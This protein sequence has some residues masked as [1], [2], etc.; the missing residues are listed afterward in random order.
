MPFSLR[1]P[2]DPMPPAT[3]PPP[4]AGLTLVEVLMA[5]AILGISAAVLMT[6]T[7]RCLAI[8]GLSKNYYEARRVL[9]LGE[10]EYPILVYKDTEAAATVTAA[11]G[12]KPGASSINSSNPEKVLNPNVGPIE[13]PKGFTFTRSCKRSETHE[14]L[15]EVQTRVTWSMRGKDAFE[16][17]TSYLY[18]TNDISL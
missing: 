4:R 14:D 17:V 10:I 13:Y 12:A 5:L 15:L 8:V 11:P 2:A 9:E 3:P 16:Q 1:M 18:F 7:S 6:A